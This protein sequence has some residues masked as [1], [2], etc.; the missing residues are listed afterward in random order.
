MFDDMYL[1][2]VE[3]N[4]DERRVILFLD[5]KRDFGDSLLG[6]LLNMF[7]SACLYFINKS[8]ALRK[9]VDNVNK[10]AGKQK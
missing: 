4:T 3:N 10:F 8:D 6:M 9:T 1:H 7:N 5:I 2:H